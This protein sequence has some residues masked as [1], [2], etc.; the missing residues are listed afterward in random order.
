MGAAAII[1]V[2]TPSSAQVTPETPSSAKAAPAKAHGAIAKR[3]KKTAPAT[4]LRSV[5]CGN[6]CSIRSVSDEQC[7]AGAEPAYTPVQHHK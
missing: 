3:K 2:A 7:A 5:G 6:A 4:R 1:A